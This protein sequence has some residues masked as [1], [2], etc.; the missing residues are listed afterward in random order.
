MS[1]IIA[2]IN[3]KGGVGKTLTAVNLGAVWSS[4]LG[5][6]VLLV[7]CDPQASA[8]AAL[9]GD[10][11]SKP[12]FYTAMTTTASRGKVPY[13][14]NILTQPVAGVPNLYLLPGH[15][16]AA[17]LESD[18]LQVYNRE[19]V[20]R[21]LLA[22]FADFDTIL[23]DC[24]PALG[25]ITV[26][27]LAAADVAVVPVVPDYISSLGL[28]KLR[29]TLTVIQ[30]QLNPDLRAVA[31]LLTRVQATNAHKTGAANIA[32]FCEDWGVTLSSVQIPN[33]IKAA[34]A[35]AAG[36]PLVDYEP[37]NPASLA[38]RQLATRLWHDILTGV[39][40]HA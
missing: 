9:G 37:E 39:P 29:D 38:Y 4:L 2:I 28:R 15:I 33:T 13:T 7:D 23:L 20:L 8:T 34:E 1:R 16:D 32:A 12:N 36:V 21:R 5:E 40:T 30:S 27:A 22:P 3:Q 18:L 35:V 17:S 14:R 19:T 6:R 11:D 25:W 10:L 31:V 24:P 26:N